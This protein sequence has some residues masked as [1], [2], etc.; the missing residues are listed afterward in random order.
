MLTAENASGNPVTGEVVA[1]G[2]VRIEEG[3]QVWVG[4]HINYNFKTHVMQSAQFRTG[5]S[6]VFAEG[7]N[8]QGN[9]HQ[10]HL[11]GGAHLS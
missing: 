11:H 2:Q 6:P 5:K 3:D 8:L 7:R 4:E 1:D 9:T 10:Q